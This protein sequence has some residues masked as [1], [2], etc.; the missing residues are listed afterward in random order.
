MAL[1][2]TPGRGVGVALGLTAAAAA[3]VAVAYSSGWLQPD[4]AAHSVGPASPGTPSP[5]PLAWRLLLAALVVHALAAVSAR[6][7]ARL[8][9]PPVVGEIVAGLLLGPSALGWAAPWLFDAVFPAEV[10]PL[11][12]LLAQT[13][14]AIFMF[15]VGTEI[16]RGVRGRDGAA[17]AGASLAIMAVPF[18]LSLLAAQPVYSILKGPSADRPTFLVFLGTALSVTAFPVLARIVH[19]CGLRDSRLGSLAMLCAAGVDVLAWCALAVVLAMTRSAGPR[20]ALVALAATLALGAAVRLVLRPLVWWLAHRYAEPGGS[21]TIPVVLVLGTILSLAAATDRIGV[22]A[23]FGGFLAGLLL[24]KDLPPLVSAAEKVGNVNR[25][26][27][28]PLFFAS[29]GLATDLQAVIDQPSVLA[30]GVLLLVTAIAGK[31]CG[32]VPV[33]RAGGLAIRPA[34]GLGILMNARGI[35][36]IVVL[37]AGLGAG[38]I[39]GG[40]FTVLVVM[41][42]V[43][44]LMAAPSLRLLGPS[45]REPVSGP[46]KPGGSRL[47]PTTV[48][49]EDAERG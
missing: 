48:G 3:I 32:A 41:A 23:I 34:L 7:A 17:I 15:T 36:E 49:Y 46:R 4:P 21:P 13:G 10:F 42:L 6:V 18:A 29:V 30:A 45:V 19:D 22:H 2:P 11:M 28:V 35:T 44:T 33:A 16:R 25:V 14:L 26:L 39:S 20:G 24:P 8:G 5:A 12:N 38:V 31:L 40:A 27:L 43:T 1:L 37:N 9:Q 47:G